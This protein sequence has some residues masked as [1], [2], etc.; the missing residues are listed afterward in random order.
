M[1]RCT[2]EAPE[3]QHRGAN[4][5]PGRNYALKLMSRNLVE[6]EKKTLQVIALL[7]RT[8]SAEPSWVAD[9]HAVLG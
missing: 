9:Q 4:L 8:A 1:F 6:R 3:E 5:E 2:L 7:Q